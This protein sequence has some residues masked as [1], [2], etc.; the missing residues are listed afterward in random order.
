[1]TAAPKKPFFS[2][3]EA[4]LR[5]ALEATTRHVLLTIGCYMNDL[6][7]SCFPSTK[8]LERD[9][10][11]SERSVIDHIK[12]AKD[13]GWLEVVAHG[14]GDR[15]WKRNEYR[16]RWPEGTEPDSVPHRGKA[17]NVMQ[18]GTERRDSK[19][20]KDVQ[21]STSGS[22][23]VNSS[24]AAVAAPA[25]GNGNGNNSGLLAVTWKS[26]LGLLGKRVNARSVE[27]WL[28]PVRLVGLKNGVA[29]L[30]APTDE[31]SA[32]VREHYADQVQGALSEATGA[33]VTR[34]D[35]CVRPNG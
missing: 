18:E 15:R 1:M 31:V 27:T 23:P 14:Y 10:G 34:L 16:V 8:T 12:K 28:R 30:V 2:W 32:W 21:C 7:E 17:L 26:A 11:L 4:I 19:A 35:V 9:T 24:R 33:A 25:K 29:V 5:S 20:L 3:R 6:G 22:T 13:A